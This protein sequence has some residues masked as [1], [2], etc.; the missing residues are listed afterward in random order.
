VNPDDRLTAFVAA[1]LERR[2]LTP[3][4]I[5]ADGKGTALLAADGDELVLVV[6]AAGHRLRP[7]NV[8]IDRIT[9][10]LADGEPVRLDHEEAAVRLAS[11]A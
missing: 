8:R 11:P 2:G 1:H 10:G 7:A 5:L 4:C 6:V 9:V 3:L